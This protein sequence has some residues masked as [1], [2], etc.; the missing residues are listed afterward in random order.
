[1]TTPGM[2]A[3]W[4]ALAAA[5]PA[6]EGRWAR[7]AEEQ[8]LVGFAIHRGEQPVPHWHIASFGLSELGDK[9]TD[10]PAVSGCGYE[11]TCRVPVS[12]S[13]EPPIWAC[14]LLLN[15]ADYVLKTGMPLGPGDNFDM[16][17]PQLGGLLSALVFAADPLVRSVD[18]P[19]GRV[20]WVQAIGITA[21]EH[22]AVRGW[23]GDSFVALLAQ[24]DPLLMTDPDRRSRLEDLEFAAHVRDG[25]ARDGSTA[26]MGKVDLVGWMRRSSEAEPPSVE[27]SLGPHAVAELRRALD[28]LVRC[29]RPWS[30][31]GDMKLTNSAAVFVRADRPGWRVD[32]EIEP[33]RPLLVIELT[34]ALID[35][36]ERDITGEPA[37]LHWPALERFTL[38]VLPQKAVDR[39]ARPR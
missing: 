36:L 13:P 27:L 14:E 39:L 4:S 26:A 5:Y 17:G 11:L 25:T 20:D 18:T 22:E 1:M 2:D 32:R 16:G 15:L 38:R 28:A 10:D 7:A 23:N 21:D 33:D 31:F 19:N 34:D 37:I 8:S 9:E 30:C 12:A 24:R 29:N 3:L 6:A 35:E